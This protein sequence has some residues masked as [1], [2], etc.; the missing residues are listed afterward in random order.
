[1]RSIK[2]NKKLQ[3][4]ICTFDIVEQYGTKSVSLTLL[5]RV[6]LNLIILFIHYNNFF[7]HY[8]TIP[9]HIKRQPF[10]MYTYLLAIVQ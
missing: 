8:C 9:R 6:K 2:K 5:K 7:L 10:K 3:A 1:M 4:S